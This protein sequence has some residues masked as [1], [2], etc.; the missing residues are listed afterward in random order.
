RKEQNPRDHEDQRIP[1]VRICFPAPRAVSLRHVPGIPPLHCRPPGRQEIPGSVSTH[2]RSYTMKLEFLARL[3]RFFAHHLSLGFPGRILRAGRQTLTERWKLVLPGKQ[4]QRLCGREKKCSA[5]FQPAK[6]LLT[7]KE[8][9]RLTCRRDAGATIFP[10]VLRLC[11]D[12]FG[13]G[14]RPPL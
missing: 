9:T 2:R 1:E 13:C 12:V 3:E 10:H 8:L 7:Q 11:G 14:R 6:V 4:T 5:G